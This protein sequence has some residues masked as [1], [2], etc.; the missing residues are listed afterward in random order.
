MLEANPAYYALY[1]YTPEEVLGKSFAVIFPE[2]QRAA[3]E[4]QYRDVFQGTVAAPS[5]TAVVRRRDGSERIVE[6]RTGFLEVGGRRA[7]MLSIVRDVTETEQARQAAAHAEQARQA[8]LSSVT[9]DLRNPLT[10][11]TGHVQLLRRAAT[12]RHTPPPVGSLLA[13]LDQ[14]ESSALRVARLV[15]ELA[16]VASLATGE[17]PPLQLAPL[18]MVT[19]AREA[20]ARQQRLADS[21]T[22]A[23]EAETATL[24]GHW[25]ATRMERV[26][27]NLLA[28]AV[29]YSPDG[30]TITV[31]VARGRWPDRTRRRGQC[32]H[33][34]DLRQPTAAVGNAGDDT[35]DGNHGGSVVPEPDGV[36]ISVQDQG[37]GIADADLPHVFER[38]RRGRNV[39]GLLGSGIG[40]TSV[41]HIVE[42][43]GGAVSLASR[44]G[45]GT[46]VSLWLPLR[47]P[48]GERASGRR[49]AH[50]TRAGGVSEGHSSPKGAGA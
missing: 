7:A 30:G 41:K 35:G 27:D 47:P 6:A 34:G 40:L 29:K 14:I 5:Y 23:L 2:D 20:V 31:R 1:G 50:V 28:N 18:D 43:H 4:A 46:T 42:L 44:E 38:F 16:E 3:A 24:P 33:S 17:V 10:A 49:P 36:T 37:I 19:L 48:A 11:I 21:H 15:D 8:F 12:R 26:L 9:H 45:A 25:D 22:V 13:G 32:G 39:G